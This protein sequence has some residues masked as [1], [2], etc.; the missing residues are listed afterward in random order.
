MAEYRGIAVFCEVTG[1]R[2]LSISLEGLG[3]GRK[4][5]DVLGHDLYAILIGSE[6]APVAR[7]AIVSGANKVYVVDSPL[8]KNY[9]AES[10]L[11]VMKNIVEQIRPEALIL[12]QDDTGR[13]LAP[14]LAFRLG[15][16]VTTDCVELSID[17]ASKRILQTKPVYGGNALAIFTSDADPQIVT[18][19]TKAMPAAA[20]DESRQGEIINV[21]DGL[22]VSIIKTKVLDRVIEKVTGVKL[23]EAQVVVAGG[24]GLGSIDGFKPLNELAALLKGAEPGRSHRQLVCARLEGSKTI[25]APAIRGYF[26]RPDQRGAGH[27]Q[28]CTRYGCAGRILDDTLKSCRHFLRKRIRQDQERGQCYRQQ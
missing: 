20:P 10:Y 27:L 22:D 2:L 6:I 18:I 8:L 17:P 12:G 25:I 11:F 14:R 28:G 26:S 24:R 21:P 19:R 5:A 16:S 1:N 9:Q 3:I 23:E 7:Q 4:L 13:D 15:T